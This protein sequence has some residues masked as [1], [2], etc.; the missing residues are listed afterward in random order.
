VELIRRNLT[1]HFQKSV[2][3]TST[4][5]VVQSVEVSVIPLQ[6]ASNAAAIATYVGGVQT[7]SVSL[8]NEDNVV[9]FSLIPSN[10]VGLSNPIN[11]RIMWRVGGV[12]GRTETYDFAM[13]DAD[14]SFDQLQSVGS[15]IGNAA[16]LQQSDLGAVGRVAKLNELGQVVDA[17]GIPVVG[18]SDI[19]AVRNA[20]NSEINAR[21]AQ[22]QQQINFFQGQIES[23]INSA[24]GTSTNQLN[25]AVSSLNSALD[26]ER[27]TRT[28]Q[29]ATTNT[30]LS[31]LQTSTTN[32]NNTLVSAVASIN[33][34]LLQKA[35][36]VNGYVPIT[37]IPPE[38]ITSWIQVS[39]A[40]D[41]FNLSYPGQ[42][43]LGDIVLA[44][45]G[46]FGLIDTN[47]ALS[48][49]WYSLSQI[50]SVNGRT[51]T[52]VLSASDVG[53]IAVGAS[54]PQSQIT[55]LSTT[56][57]G[58][59]S[60]STTT[61]LQQ[62]ITAIQN[63]TKI[64]R[65]DS[66]NLISNTLLDSSVAYVNALNQITKKD[67]TVLGT[68]GGGSVFS[69]NG[70]TGVITLNAA[71]VGAVAVGA[72]I[73]QSQVTGLT[74]LLGTKADLVTGKVPLAQIP[75]LPQT[76]ITGL[77]TSLG[78]KADLVTGT[79]PLAQIPTMPTS[80]ITGLESIISNNGLT[81]STNALARISA[82]ETLSVGGGGGG[83]GGTTS[84]TTVFWNSFILDSDVVDFSNVTL[85]SPF[86]IYSAGANLGQ[87]YYRRNGVPAQDVA[88]PYITEGGHLELRKWNESNPP[89]PVYALA[90]TVTTLS[91]NLTDLS[92]SVALKANQTSITS[93]NSSI[94]GLTNNKA[95]LV[96][97]KV[98]VGEIPVLPQSQIDGLATALAAK[99]GLVGGVIP[100]A[101]IPTAIPQ[102]S[103]V[104][105]S[106]AFAGK[107]DLS[108]GVLAV[109]QIPTN[110]PQASVTGLTAALDARATLVSGKIPVANIPVAIPQANIDGLTA[111][112]ATKPTLVGGVVPVAQI[113]T[114]IP[115]SSIVG[116]N[117]SAKADL[118]SGVLSTS[119]IPSSLIR[120]PQ[121]VGAIASMKALT[122]PQQVNVGD[123]CIITGT[124]DMGTYVLTGNR[125]DL[126]GSAGG[127]YINP[128]PFGI[129]K[130][131]SGTGGTKLP[132]SSGNISLIPSDI[133]AMAS[134]ASIPQSQITG[135]ATSL[136]LLATT[137]SLTSGLASKVGNADVVNVVGT[138]QVFRGRVDYAVQRFVD[139]T[140]TVRCNTGVPEPPSGAPIIDM[141]STGATIT[142]PNN[143]LVLLTNQSNS[144]LNGIWQ[145]KTAGAW[146]RPPDY[147]SGTTVFPDTTVIVNNSTSVNAIGTR[148]VSCFS[149]WQNYS[150][151]SAVVDATGSV[152]ASTSWYNIGT[153][154]PRVNL[155]ATK[156]IA[157][158]ATSAYPNITL[159][160]VVAPGQGLVAASG[161]FQIDTTSVVRK[162]NT[163][164]TPSTSIVSV[165]HNLNTTSPQVTVIDNLSNN[166]VLLG[167]RADSAN[168]VRLEFGSS[169]INKAYRVSVQG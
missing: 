128:A 117:L 125:P 161:G 28:N 166:V 152:N 80:K 168:T 9:S 75:T 124:A 50:S 55:G 29:L 106:T 169:F 99:A 116:L 19:T 66:N 149:I 146:I 143:A 70:Q 155:T 23:Q 2:K 95:N 88:F 79:V 108:G 111:A 4:D 21:L 78:S 84:S 67:G 139:G 38:A 65:L 115:Q 40:A 11:Y 31:A 112:L 39:A 62:S 72:S 91:G 122:T 120:R 16:Y 103:I 36:L 54:I 17:F 51:G 57:A 77:S 44:P 92:N 150:T 156:G 141:D 130:S 113:P 56:L 87:R 64:V 107:A 45:T 142:A 123:Q 162:H 126:V 132:D 82:L 43:Q 61:S 69:V 1:I 154:A 119:Q 148:G 20:L 24:I 93:I 3:V 90:S 59:A 74:T 135:L 144:R 14:I 71:Q 49:S 127:W 53:A 100:I 52:V 145:A 109:A 42:I 110:I 25:L 163:T 97:G 76:Q 118:T 153:V 48:S 32:N 102:S 157:I 96:S 13:P 147:A 160:G 164:V 129:V 41:R 104:G 138:T 27:V 6:D 105:L 12:S 63:D 94:T 140:N 131:L 137:A 85:N 167:W 165:T 83:G 10:S 26:T 35:S 73:P 47:P 136:G 68:G 151:V 101:Q 22:D 89:D 37:Q 114:N 7:T 30:N 46:L 81:G 158:S 8:L 98:P 121:I 159:E 33:N 34:E 5:V 133:G 18:S 86:G 134:N 58:L 60:T 15:I